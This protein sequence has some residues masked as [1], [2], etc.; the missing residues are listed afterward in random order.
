[1]NFLNLGWS[2][3]ILILL[4]A[5]IVLGPDKVVKTGQDL[6]KW[7]RKVSKDETIRE[8]VRTTNE[9]KRFPQKILDESGLDLPPHVELERINVEASEEN[10]Q[11]EASDDGSVAGSEN[12]T[13][14]HSTP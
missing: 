6:G 3:V 11:T 13:L 12:E 7:I 8:V 5:F 10:S 9:I 1:M 4:L 14:P 2:E